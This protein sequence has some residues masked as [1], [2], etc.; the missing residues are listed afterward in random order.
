M[1]KKE[2]QEIIEVL[3]Q[4][5][6]KDKE[7]DVY[8]F[9][10]KSGRQTI[11]PVARALG[12][13]ATTVQS[14]LLRLSDSGLLDVTA[15]KSRH[16]FE[17]KAPSVLKN[18]LEERIESVSGIIPLLNKLKADEKMKSRV[19]VYYRERVA[20]VF[21]EALEAK[22]KTVFEI[23]SARDLQ[24]VIGERLHFTKRRKEKGVHLKSLRVEKYEIKK[25]NKSIH[26]KELREAKFLPQGTSF[27]SS[28]MF[29]DDKV[30][31]FST[32]DEGLS[33]VIESPAM[34]L[35]IRQIFDILWDVSRRMENLSE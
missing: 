30:A 13:P 26:E 4:F 17:A 35:M 6:L 1:P 15:N 19:R 3:G 22:D 28:L 2:Q 14:I 20:D 27:R 18:I 25:Y 7:I 23:V 8:L 34:T 33:V 31:F 24:W 29:W 32:K 5:G 21:Y 16:G 11:T 12:F 10:L 9:L